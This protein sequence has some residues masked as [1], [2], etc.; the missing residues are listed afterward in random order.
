[1]CCRRKSWKRWRGRREFSTK[2]GSHAG[3]GF[4]IF[5]SPSVNSQPVRT[6]PA[7]GNGN[8]QFTDTN[9]NNRQKFYRAVGQ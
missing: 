3:A 1:M 9:L 5:P 8:W 7:A 4:I 2:A 6:N